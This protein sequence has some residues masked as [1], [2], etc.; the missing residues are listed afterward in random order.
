MNLAKFL[1][2][3]FTEHLCATASV[4]N[5]TSSA[6]SASLFKIKQ[7]AA[8][9]DTKL[10]DH[11]HPTFSRSHHQIAVFLLNGVINDEEDPEPD[12]ENVLNERH[13]NNIEFN[14]TQVA[15]NTEIAE[16]HVTSAEEDGSNGDDVEGDQFQLPFI[17][18]LEHEAGTFGSNGVDSV[19]SYSIN[20]E[21]DSNNGVTYHNVNEEENQNIIS[22]ESLAIVVV[23]N[24]NGHIP[25]NLLLTEVEHNDLNLENSTIENSCVAEENKKAI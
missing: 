18:T 19:R 6:F 3:L 1:R 11:F 7:D 14:E 21:N 16:K 13:D 12:D 23:P 9:L 4:F 10:L 15:T 24:Q 8:I 5:I 2:T 22:N 17:V 25:E 20:G